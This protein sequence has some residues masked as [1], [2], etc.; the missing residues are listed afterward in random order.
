MKS[1]I[2]SLILMTTTL[3]PS[4]AQFLTE[5]ELTGK[6]KVINANF[7]IPDVREEQKAN[8]KLIKEAFLKSTFDFGVGHLFSL[9]ISIPEL[10]V[11]KG[12][13]T[14]D[15]TTNTTKITEV[16]SITGNNN[17]LMELSASKESNKI[18]FLIS[19]MFLQLEVKKK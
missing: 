15:N 16:N 9:T 6:W 2:A 13:W 1:L 14:T 18:I 3:L 11:N 12:N 5:N 4:Q 7:L 17:L 10:A 19:E 8:L